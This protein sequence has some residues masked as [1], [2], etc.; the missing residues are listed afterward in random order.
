MHLIG[1]HRLLI[2]CAAVF[3]F[4]YGAWEL[5]GYRASGAAVRLV[6]GAGSLLAGIALTYYLL[7]LRRFL[8]L[9]D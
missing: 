4:G 2:G 1:F 9:P 6:F 7:R 3:F 8:R 5:I